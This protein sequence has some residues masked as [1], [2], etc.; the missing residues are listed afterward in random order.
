M[1]YELYYW[2][3]I[4]GRGEFVRLALEEAGAAYTDVAR[5][6]S[7]QRRLSAFLNDAKNTHPTFALPALKDGD[8]VIGQTAAILLYLGDKLRL[9]PKNPEQRVWTHQIQLTV[10]DL[11]NAVHDAHHPLGAHLYYED[12]QEEAAKRTAAFRSKRL[13]QFLQWFETILANNPEGPACLVGS[14]L[15]YADLSLF[16]VMEGLT[17]AF[18]KRMATLRRRLPH[19][20]ALHAAV[21]ERPNIQIYLA[22]PRRIPFNTDGIF[23][24]YPELDV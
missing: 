13:P 17:Y 6:K 11:V 18:P 20:K 8:T 4:P 10:A 14:K 19:L 23:R 22:S 9:A 21:A 2:G 3:E 16:Q 24:H 15:T 12:Q 5:G 1:A 7:G